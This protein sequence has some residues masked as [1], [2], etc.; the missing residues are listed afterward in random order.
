MKFDNYDQTKHEKS[1]KKRLLA[2]KRLLSE[3]VN[4]RRYKRP[5]SSAAELA[6]ESGLSRQH[7][8]RLESLEHDIRIGTLM[9]Y[10]DTFDYSLIIVPRK[11]IKEIEPSSTL[12]KIELLDKLF[13]KLNAL[14]ID[15]LLRLDKELP[16]KNIGTGKQSEV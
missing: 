4:I 14:T 12:A 13:M 8:Y 16:D 10:L 11:N 1:T 7:I 5:D 15:E 9:D 6:L 2:Y 3:A